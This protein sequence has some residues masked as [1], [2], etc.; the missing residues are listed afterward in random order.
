[1]AETSVDSEEEIGSPTSNINLSDVFTTALISTIPE[2]AVKNLNEDLNTS[3][4]SEDNPDL[5]PV[6]TFNASGTD[7][8]K[9]HAPIRLSPAELR[10]VMLNEL[11]KQ[12]EIL[13]YELEL[14]EI[15]QEH[16]I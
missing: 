12:D 4:Y 14:S 3:I 9:P 13:N 10:Q 15:E 11:R 5:D 7:S 16:N 2:I 6:R 1:M 8:S